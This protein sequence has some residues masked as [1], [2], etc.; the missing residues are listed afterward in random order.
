AAGLE[1]AERNKKELEFGEHKV[2]TMIH[3]AKIQAT[4]IIDQANKRSA[5]LLDEAK[6]QAREEQKRIIA[7]AQEEITRE[8]N[9]AKEKLKKQVA[10]LAIAGAEKLVRH[11]LDSTKQMALLD[12]FVAL[13]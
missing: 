7:L 13:I 2:M 6:E 4:Q 12:E 10:S 8:V 5:L 3:E 11:N 9:Q 1:A